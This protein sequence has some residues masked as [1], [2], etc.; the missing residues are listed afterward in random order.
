MTWTRALRRARLV[1][2][3]TE[4]KRCQ[5][6]AWLRRRCSCEQ[7]RYLPSVSSLNS[8]GAPIVALSVFGG[9]SLAGS[10]TKDH[11]LHVERGRAATDQHVR[12]HA[13]DKEPKSVRT[14]VDEGVQHETDAFRG[15]AMHG[16]RNRF[17]DTPGNCRRAAR[18][19]GTTRRARLTG[20]LGCGASLPRPQGSARASTSLQCVRTPDALPRGV[21]AP[22]RSTA[23]RSAHS[24]I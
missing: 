2:S 14:I 8:S 22:R 6:R 3:V 10:R 17:C 13:R 7:Q 5:P 16:V 19:R 21:D 24:G 1:S 9:C 20:F 15:V 18:A 11:L 23:R 4:P 12:T